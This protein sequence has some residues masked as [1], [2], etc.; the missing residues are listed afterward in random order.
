MSELKECHYSE[1]EIQGAIDR[2]TIAA[3]HKNPIYLW[4]IDCHV[5]LW[6][7]E[8]RSTPASE[9]LTNGDKI[10]SMS[11]VELAKIIECPYLHNRSFECSNTDEKT[12]C[13]KCRID[14]LKEEA[15]E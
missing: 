14:W 10:R 2:M 8:N 1:S 3:N 7:L 9:H 4:P 5:A 6:F 12:N 13:L 11:D 15:K